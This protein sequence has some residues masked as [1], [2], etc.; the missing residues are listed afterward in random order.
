MFYSASFEKKSKK[1]QKTY[2]L[3]LIFVPMAIYG[4]AV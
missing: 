2:E 4:T 3:L 1:K